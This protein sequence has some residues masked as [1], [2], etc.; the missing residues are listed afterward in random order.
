MID[1][2]EKSDI[3]RE[4]NVKALAKQRTSDSGKP[5]LERNDSCG[6]FDL[7]ERKFASHP[8]TRFLMLTTPPGITPLE[9]IDE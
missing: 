8:R 3:W 9:I 6:E 2:R 4:A 7:W 1:R 5:S